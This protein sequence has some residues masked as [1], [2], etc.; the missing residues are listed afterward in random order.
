M[1]LPFDRSRDCGAGAY[2]DRMPERLVLEG[3]RHWTAGY[4]TSSVVPWELAWRLYDGLLGTEEAKHALAELAHFVRVMVQCAS[5]PLRSFPSGARHLCREECLA[6]GLVAG[7]QHS[8]DLTVGRCLNALTCPRRC[9]A[10][11]LAAGSFAI[12]LKSMN[13]L[14]LPIPASVIDEVT[15]RGGRNDTIH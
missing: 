9:E 14:L 15:A 3:Y 2:L 8:D 13:Q 4:Q 1:G 12:T 10:I 11:A 5:C 6:L 7:V